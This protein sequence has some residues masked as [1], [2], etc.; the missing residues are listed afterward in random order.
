[1]QSTEDFSGG[2]RTR[3]A[4]MGDTCHYTFGKTCRMYTT[5]SEHYVNYGLWVLICIS[6]QQD[7]GWEGCGCIWNRYIWERCT[8]LNFALNVKLLLKL[9]FEKI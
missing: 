9:V 6:R 7:I 4:I 2:E 5:K 8:L 1:M 3:Y